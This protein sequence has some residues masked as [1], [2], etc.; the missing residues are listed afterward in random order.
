MK[1]RPIVAFL[2][3]AFAITVTTFSLYADDC[4]SG[5]CSESPWCIDPWTGKIGFGLSDLKGNTVSQSL[6]L[7]F[8]A[9]YKI[10]FCERPHS[11]W[12]VGGEYKYKEED[13][14]DTVNKARSKIWYQHWIMPCVAVRIKEAL[15]FD[16]GKD[17]TFR[18]DS[19]LSLGYFVYDTDDLVLLLLFGISR[20]D[21]HYRLEKDNIHDLNLPLGV[22]V[23]WCFVMDWSIKNELEYSP[24]I[25][26]ADHYRIENNLELEHRISKCW[27][28]TVGHNYIYLS[29]PASGKKYYDSALKSKL[30]YRF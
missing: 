20:D 29:R 12:H 28:F 25:E 10:C 21:A 2:I 16:Q 6:D 27:S 5:E 4:D 3:S 11:A 26:H 30:C 1:R 15:S 18:L 24:I 9:D 13:N 7:D 23:K 8:E 17:L 19:T 22:E 14:K